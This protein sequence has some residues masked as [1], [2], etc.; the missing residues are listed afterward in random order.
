MAEVLD[1]GWE[2]LARGSWEEALA[3]LQWRRRRPRGARG[4]GHRA[5]VARRRRCD[6]RGARA[7]LP[8]LP[9]ARRPPGR[10]PRRQ[11]AGVGLRALRRPHRGRRAAGSSARG[12]CSRTS[13][14]A[15][16][17]RGSPCARPRS[18]WHPASRRS[19]VRPPSARS[20]SPARST[21][22]DV[23]VVGRSLEGLSLVHEGLG[24]R[25]HAAARRVGRRRDRGR[26]QGPDVG[27][28]G[29]LQPDRRVRARRRR[30]ARDAVVRAGQG[31]RAALGAADALQRLPDAVR[32]GAPADRRL[33]RGR[34]RAQHG[35]RGVQRAGGAPRSSTARPSSASCAA[36]R[37]GSTRR[38]SLFARS[39]AAWTARIGSVELALDEGDTATALALAE[40]LER[41]T[42]E[43]RRLDRAAVLVA[44]RARGDRRRARRRCARSASHELDGLAESIATDRVRASAAHAGGDDRARDRRPRAGAP[45][46]RGRGRPARAL[47]GALRAGA[48]AARA[49]ARALRAR[50][51]EP[52]ARRGDDRARRVLR[53][54]RAP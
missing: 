40:R 10:G 45:Q 9:G 35:A 44:A 43:G 22:E 31:V 32:L 17:R 37:A 49:R 12:A 6:V 25:G 4:G 14:R 39:E 8:P 50:A 11:R 26:R 52:G 47:R 19:R 34:G 33:E 15:P 54:R 48:R 16:S 7:R 38:A 41:A 42:E 29:V 53:P 18:R 2:A 20:R 5:L 13:R 28:Q 30:R 51:R 24:R 21:R 1:A 36:A 46:A 3:L 23:Q 27:R